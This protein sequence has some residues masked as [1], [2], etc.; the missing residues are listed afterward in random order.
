MPDAAA[1]STW[2]S[3]QLPLPP[4][5]VLP[6]AFIYLPI[7]AGGAA[8]EQDFGRA[9]VLP[10]TQDLIAPLGDQLDDVG[11]YYSQT[12]ASFDSAIHFTNLMSVTQLFTVTL[13]SDTGVVVQ[14][15]TACHIAPQAEYALSAEGGKVIFQDVSSGASVDICDP[16]DNSRELHGIYHA[17]ITAQVADALEIQVDNQIDSASSMIYVA[18]NSQYSAIA[19]TGLSNVAH[20]AAVLATRDTENWWDTEIVV[21][22][23]SAAAAE[24]T[25][26][27]C[28]AEGNCFQ[29]NRAI[30]DAYERRSFLASHLLYE[31][32]DG[33]LLERRGWF[34]VT[35]T[36]RSWQNDAETP[37]IAAVSH[38]FRQPVLSGAV[39][40]VSEWGSQCL[41][42]I[43]HQSGVTSAHYPL[44]DGVAASALI[45]I[46]N[47]N[48]SYNPLT[49]QLVDQSGAI[50]TSLRQVLLPQHTMTW[51]L[52]DLFA[53]ANGALSQSEISVQ[54]LRAEDISLYILAD[55]AVVASVWNNGQ[56]VEPL[57]S[58][59]HTARWFVPFVGFPLV[60]FRWD[61]GVNSVADQPG[62]RFG[63]GETFGRAHTARPDWARALNWYS[64]SA[65]REFCDLVVG[66]NAA[67]S[68]YIPMWWGLGGCSAD[69][70]D[71]S[72]V[73]SAE[74]LR[75]VR[76]DLSSNCAGR[77]LFL[78]NEPDLPWQGYMTYHE[79]GRL[80]YVLRDWPGQLFSP[81][82]ASYR[83]DA[84]NRIYE[85]DA[86][87]ADNYAHSC[88]GDIQCSRC[89]RDGIDDGRDDP[90]DISFQG[91]ENFFAERDR[92]AYGQSW[93]FADYVEGM[94]LHFYTDVASIATD[95]HWR[96]PFLQ[97][98]RDRAD[99]AGWPIIVKEYGF[100]TWRNQFN[101]PNNISQCEITRYLD[102]VR[103]VLQQNLG[104][105]ESIHNNNPFKLFWFHSG[106]IP[107][108]LPEY[109]K[110]CL[111]QATQPAQLSSPVGAC[112]AND[113][114]TQGEE[115]SICSCSDTYLPIAPK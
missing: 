46:F 115:D 36:A 58:P 74:R 27:M 17:E 84:P 39:H 91:L 26:D 6:S 43:E 107:G 76:N 30:L 21:Q 81:T 71:R 72:C 1:P 15:L 29:N 57:L 92:W 106:C 95:T 51:R 113:A 13:F 10:K 65:N 97:Q 38:I 60:D 111:F 22:N 73:N 28:D 53:Q 50:I 4:S 24:L 9:T 32:K 25:F 8:H 88:P 66:E 61:V 55:D 37:K 68:T 110:V 83:Y 82:F 67:Y 48:K 87:C 75:K 47:R 104:N 54:Q 23:V 16:S 18:A 105:Y 101:D 11:Q 52:A 33:F 35:A 102:N 44:E 89:V 103:R 56:F 63:L 12:A 93:R 108:A 86:W 42:A 64:W 96:I 80:I 114:A 98:Y 40:P 19:D 79:L 69:I 94:N 59:A 20:T 45:R 34:A 85:E 100:I 2:C 99:K 77:P 109:D 78:A 90:H 14:N 5:T 49:L 70:S 31:N 62:P 41:F 7:G 3:E 112:W